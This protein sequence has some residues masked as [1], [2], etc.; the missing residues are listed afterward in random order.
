M[1][2][3][4]I[5]WRS[6]EAPRSRRQVRCPFNTAAYVSG[7]ANPDT[8]RVH[9]AGR[10]PILVR[11]IGGTDHRDGIGPWPYLWIEDDSDVAALCEDFGDLVTLT[12]V[13]QPGYVPDGRGDP[14]LLKQHYVYDPRLPLPAL[15]A[16]ARARLR[17]SE[18]IGSF[19]VV[20]DTAGRM[21]MV[22]L[23]ESLKRRR[24]LTGMFL[25]M[26]ARHFESI[27]R[28]ESSIFF[29]AVSDT[30]I[31][32]MACG[33]LFGDLLQILHIVPSETGLTW[34]ASYLLMRGIQ[35]FAGEKGVR[36]MTGGM[37]AGG[38]EG[39]RLF[40]ARWANAFEPVYLLRIVNDPVAYAAL[41]AA[42]P[43][44]DVY[45]PAYRRP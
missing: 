9:P 40:K 28:L 13:T 33:V 30:G 41:C 34:N 7:L 39:L 24:N 42:A 20:T 11:P 1:E 25:D 10:F 45:F 29:R 22:E 35:E 5:A 23:Y 36:M 3:R 6:K 12:V 43:S 18:R 15:S 37:P 21:A 19:S 17:M 4:A 27:A 2:D 31:G 38:T 14:I 32:A 16:R 8:V 44:G 26:G